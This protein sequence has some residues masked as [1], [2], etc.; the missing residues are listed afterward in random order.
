VPPNDN[1]LT[2]TF[3]IPHAVEQEDPPGIPAGVCH[4]AGERWLLELNW[5]VI[6]PIINLSRGAVGS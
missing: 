6:G 5:I 4:A 2:I 1:R 3:E